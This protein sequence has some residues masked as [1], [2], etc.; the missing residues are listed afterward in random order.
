[1]SEITAEVCGLLASLVL[2]FPALR[3]SHI[4]KL[5]IK[6]RGQQEAA[7]SL[8]KL[9]RGWLEFVDDEMKT[10]DAKD[11]SFLLLGLV[12]LIIAFSLKIFFL[13]SE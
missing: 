6:V 9:A 11:Y 3:R 7:S 2:L 10:W 5:V 1:M 13:V 8:D 12:L 4:S